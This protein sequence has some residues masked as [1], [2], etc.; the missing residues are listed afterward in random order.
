MD[1][2]ATQ[3]CWTG[4]EVAAEEVD[5]AELDG[6][7]GDDATTPIVDLTATQSSGAVYPRSTMP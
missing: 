3:Q 4:D 5:Q 1:E 2:D 7:A 6:E